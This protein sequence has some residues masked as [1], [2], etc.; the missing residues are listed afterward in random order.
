MKVTGTCTY[1]S[2]TLSCPIFPQLPPIISRT[3]SCPIFPIIPSLHLHACHRVLGFFD[4]YPAGG[5]GA[6]LLK[7]FLSSPVGLVTCPIGLP[8]VMWAWWMLAIPDF[9]TKLW[10]AGDSRR[11]FRELL[12]GGGLE[13]VIVLKPPKTICLSVNNWWLCL[14]TFWIVAA[15]FPGKRWFL[16]LIRQFYRGWA[17]SWTW[18][19]PPYISASRTLLLAVTELGGLKS[20]NNLSKMDM[21]FSSSEVEVWRQ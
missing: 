17:C 15:T 6:G 14:P 16:L 18:E 19:N 2:H 7:V 9:I 11:L 1:I 13:G 5:Y 21:V 20:F 8:R 4:A 10:A 12:G 3:S